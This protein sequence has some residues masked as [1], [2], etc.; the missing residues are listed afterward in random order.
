MLRIAASQGIQHCDGLT[1]RELLRAGA[2]GL[3]GLTLPGLL[4]LEQTVPA[5]Q[6]A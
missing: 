5:S 4:Q 2:I 3:A 6:P 1:R